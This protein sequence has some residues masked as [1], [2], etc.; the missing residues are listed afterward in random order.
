[1]ALGRAT[2]LTPWIATLSS[3]T[4][5]IG[6]AVSHVCSTQPQCRMVDVVDVYTRQRVVNEF[7]TEEGSSPIEIHKH[8]RSM[9]VEYATDWACHFK[10]GGNDTGDR[11][12]S[13]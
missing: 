12:C 6:A 4:G 3:S 1:V 13:S 10:S 5:I 9:Y 7:L 8:L 2:C 11:P